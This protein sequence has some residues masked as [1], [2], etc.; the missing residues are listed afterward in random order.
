MLAGRRALAAGAF[1]ETLATFDH[2]LSLELPEDDPLLG[3]ACEHR[4]EALAG[5]QR[6][7]DAVAAFERA[8]T[9]AVARHDDAGIERAAMGASNCHAVAGHAGRE[10]GAAETRAGRP[11]E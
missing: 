11:H 3:E 9:I 4:G 5:L 10:S 8:L 6:Y 2:M 7:D 1:E